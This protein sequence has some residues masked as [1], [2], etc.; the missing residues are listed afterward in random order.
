MLTYC[1]L[2]SDKL[3]VDPDKIVLDKLEVTRSKYPAELSRDR[4]EKYDQ[5]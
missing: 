5:L 4:S 1:H 3:G 2:L